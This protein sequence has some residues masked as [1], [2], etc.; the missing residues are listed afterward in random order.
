MAQHMAQQNAE[1]SRD[2]S[3]LVDASAE[4]QH[5]VQTIWRLRQPDGC[6]WDRE[7]TPRSIGK[8]MIEEAYEALDCIEADDAAH[9][10]EEL[11]D[12]LL[13]VVL[14]SQIAAD[15]GE[16]DI[17]DVAAD[18]DAK[19]VRR[20]PHVFGDEAAAGASSPNT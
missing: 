8:N 5:L 16:F 3:T 17:E 9:L 11:G 20:H 12:V 19:M 15:A 18:V 7:Q 6:L 4:L 2:L 10:R 1:G 14:Q 13:Q